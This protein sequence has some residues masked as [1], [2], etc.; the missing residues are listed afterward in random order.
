MYDPNLLPDILEEAIGATSTIIKRCAKATCMDDFLDD[1][2][3]QMRLDSICMLLI[4]VGESIKQID[5][6]TD[7]KLL[8]R[9]TS[10]PWKKVM[11]IR[12]VLSHHYFD[13]NAEI[14][15]NLCQTHIAPLHTT[16]IKIH[17]DSQP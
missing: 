6:I 4:A 5:K 2:E 3:G 10:V 9:Y 14:I 11:A 17:Q 12:D 15:F 16:L 1:E 13:L 8:S 7:K